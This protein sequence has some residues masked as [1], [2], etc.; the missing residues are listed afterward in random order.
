MKLVN[1]NFFF[2]EKR[3]LLAMFEC[4]LIIYKAYC[5]HLLAMHFFQVC[6]MCATSCYICVVDVGVN[7]GIVKS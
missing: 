2:M 7:I 3:C 5:M 6:K 4:S 1:I